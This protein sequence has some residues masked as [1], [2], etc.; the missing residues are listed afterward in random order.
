MLRI[1]LSPTV[2]RCGRSD[3]RRPRSISSTE[4]LHTSITYDSD[5]A[6]CLGAKGPARWEPSSSNA[7]VTRTAFIK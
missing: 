5:G 2:K 7:A 4:S 3:L 1:V 6:V